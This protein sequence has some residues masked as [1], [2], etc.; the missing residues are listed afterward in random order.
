[1][2]D[3]G[4]K[5]AQNEF[6]K[7]GLTVVYITGEIL[8]FIKIL[9]IT[10]WAQVSSI[11]KINE[12]LP[13]TTNSLESINGHLNA[14]T[15]RRNVFWASMMRMCK[16]IRHGVQHHAAS[17]LHNF[18]T[19]TRRIYKLVKSIGEEEIRQQQI[20]Y[21]TNI[22]SSPPTCDC[23]MSLYF[24]QMF[25]RFVPC[26]HMV[27]AGCPKQIFTGSADLVFT[28]DT[29]FR[30]VLEKASRQGE[31]PSLER[32]DG[33]V[34]LATRSIKHLSKTGT[35]LDEIREWVEANFPSHDQMT[36]FVINIPIP[37]LHLISIGVMNF[38]PARDPEG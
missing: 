2:S 18:H 1:L 21:K 28:E 9:D 17:V 5:R 15:P 4:L 25:G 11:F 23:G 38:G 33:L 7:A 16:M 35:K 37:I 34:E 10:R 32:R 12:G 36:V 27:H 29:Q 3:V 6:R 13:M 22:N 20:Y 31:E 24:T 26:S 30:L 8:P 14:E 19:T